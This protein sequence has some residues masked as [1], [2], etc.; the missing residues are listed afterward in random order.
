MDVKPQTQNNHREG[1]LIAFMDLVHELTDMDF[2]SKGDITEDQKTMKR[3][4]IIK[5]IRIFDITTIGNL[6]L[7]SGGR[8]VLDNGYGE[9]FTEADQLLFTPEELKSG[10]KLNKFMEKLNETK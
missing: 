9:Y 4:E 8:I 2:S 3:D 7:T 5:K 10:I 6:Y 1:T